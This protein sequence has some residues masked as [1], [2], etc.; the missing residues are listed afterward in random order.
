MS[1]VTGI[2]NRL[3]ALDFPDIFKPLSKAEQMSV[4]RPA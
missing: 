4:A 2:L 1:H 3:A